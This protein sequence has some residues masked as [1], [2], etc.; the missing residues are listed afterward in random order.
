MSLAS[1]RQRFIELSEL[2][3]DGKNPKEIISNQK[4]AQS[5]TVSK[6]VLAWYA[7]YIEKKR[8]QPQ[9]I[10]QLIDADTGGN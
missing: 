3:R 8:K 4:E 5:N 10:K 6:L 1:A 7:G 9:Q 2:C